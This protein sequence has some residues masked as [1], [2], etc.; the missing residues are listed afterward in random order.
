MPPVI[1]LQK[2]K[3]RSWF[4]SLLFLNII[5]IL[6]SR[7]YLAPLTGSE[8]VKFETAKV[9][10]KAQAIIG[11]WNATGK[12]EKAVQG[13]W[14]DYFFILLYVSGLMLAAMFL[15][16]ATH[17]SLLMRSGRFFRWL[18]PFAGICDIMENIFMMR[19][20]ESHPTKLSVMLAY[21]MAVT[22]FSILIVT[23]LFFILCLLF[24][25]MRKIFPATV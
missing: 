3:V 21:D 18:I 9:V 23:F 11:D 7:F 13:V 24:W 8:I 5:F 15:S 16:D 14:I 19:S 22:K 17:Y 20:L 10:S 6:A 12:F 1:S 25:V 2:S 4:W